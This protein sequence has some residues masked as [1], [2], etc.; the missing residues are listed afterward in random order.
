MLTK[1]TASE[2]PNVD[3]ANLLARAFDCINLFD[4]SQQHLFPILKRWAE[5]R[6]SLEP[7]KL[8]STLQLASVQET[9][10]TGRPDSFATVGGPM[11]GLRK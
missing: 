8:S 5:I 4:S 1:I 11:E 10:R 6:P 2:S 7:L 3:E 9:P